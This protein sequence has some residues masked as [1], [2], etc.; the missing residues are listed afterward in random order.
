[1]ENDE[2]EKYHVAHE[3]CKSIVFADE[4]FSISEAKNELIQLGVSDFRVD[5]LTRPYTAEQIK[6]VVRSCWNSEKIEKT[7]PA[8]F[9]RELL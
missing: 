9:Y 7:H 5:F 6:T 8:N 4:G 1:M 2:G 3:S